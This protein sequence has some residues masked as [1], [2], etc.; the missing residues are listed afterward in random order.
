MPEA[1]S[2]G[3]KSPKPRV[4]EPERSQGEMRFE[5]PDLLVSAKHPAHLIWNVLGTVDLSA[6]EE[7]CGSVEGKAGPGLLSPRMFLT[8]WFYALSKAIGSALEISRLILTDSTYCWIGRALN[9][10]AHKL[11]EFV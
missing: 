6:F 5:I 10:G 9:V 1:N 4:V 7:K 11:S 2:P 3:T 8:W